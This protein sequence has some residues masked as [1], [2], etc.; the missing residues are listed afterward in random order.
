MS[1]QGSRLGL[2][3][4]N[5]LSKCL[6]Q[7]CKILPIRIHRCLYFTTMTM[8]NRGMKVVQYIQLC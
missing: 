4:M 3:A 5:M 6:G 7:T 8:G 2:A 1:A